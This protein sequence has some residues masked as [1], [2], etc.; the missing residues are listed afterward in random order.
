MGKPIHHLRR[1]VLL[2]VF[3]AGVAAVFL[4]PR[5]DAVD[6][7]ATSRHPLLSPSGRYQIQVTTGFDG[8]VHFARFEIARAAKAG[9]SPEVV[10]ICPESY[11]TR[12]A[13]Y[14]LWDESDRVW[15]YSGDLG[16]FYWTKEADDSWRKHSYATERIPVPLKLK[17]KRPKEFS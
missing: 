5:T 17:Q 14:F 11:R 7:F 12:D 8:V 6:D 13:L 15:V 4:L 1:L 3:L 9:R 10:F 2:T 16:V